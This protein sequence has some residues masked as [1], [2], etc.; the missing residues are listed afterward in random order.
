MRRA[1]IATGSG[2]F[3]LVLASGVALSLLLIPVRWYQEERDVRE[4]PQRCPLVGEFA[5]TE[6]YLGGWASPDS[7]GYFDASGQE[8]HRD[9]S[10][11]GPVLRERRPITRDGIPAAVAGLCIVACAGA[12]G[13]SVV[14]R[15]D[16]GAP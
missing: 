10:Y 12:I 5:R 1:L 16:W 7:C 2:V 11:A 8:I 14:R 3:L 13:V 6:V 9:S 4:D 15:T